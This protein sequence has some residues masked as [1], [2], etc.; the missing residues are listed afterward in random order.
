MEGSNTRAVA[1][2]ET[3][4]ASAVPSVTP[5]TS[6]GVTLGTSVTVLWTTTGAVSNVGVQLRHSGS[7][8]QTLISSTTNDGSFTWNIPS[9]GTTVGLASMIFSPPQYFD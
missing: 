5:L 1:A 8:V 6:G 9:S 2:G 7:L 3:W 4:I